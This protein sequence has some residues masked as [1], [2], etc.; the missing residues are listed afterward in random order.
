MLR[1]C[2]PL[3]KHANTCYSIHTLVGECWTIGTSHIELWAS[4]SALGREI[5]SLRVTK[6]P[7]GQLGDLITWSIGNAIYSP[8][9]DAPELP[10]TWFFGK[11]KRPQKSSRYKNTMH[12]NQTAP[13]SK[14]VAK[15]LTRYD[16]RTSPRDFTSTLM[17]VAEQIENIN[18]QNKKNCY[19]YKYIFIQKIHV[20]SL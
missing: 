3:E 8:A 14:T 15:L 6:G 9:Y 5:K 12:P 1:A 11:G 4:S 13:H 20:F 19:M 2:R 17:Y 7:P 18:R 16:L 10:W